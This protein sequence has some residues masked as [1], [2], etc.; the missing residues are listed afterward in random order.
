M[1]RRIRRNGLA[2][3]PKRTSACMIHYTCVYIRAGWRLLRLGT[4]SRGL[5]TLGP[6]PQKPSAHSNIY[7]CKVYHACAGPF[8]RMRQSI[9]ANAPVHFIE[10]ACL[11]WRM[12]YFIP[13]FYYIKSIRREEIAGGVFLLTDSRHYA[14]DSFFSLAHSW[15]IFFWNE[16]KSI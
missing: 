12:S 8:W 7:T 9:L 16:P 13:H 11:F 10:C 5:G 3:L 15:S 1:D 2:H 4:L 14:I 6:M